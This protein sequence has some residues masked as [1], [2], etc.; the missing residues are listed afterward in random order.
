MRGIVIKNVPSV[1]GE[2]KVKR[3]DSNLVIVTGATQP[4]KSVE[5][6][7]D[8]RRSRY[9]WIIEKYKDGDLH[10]KPIK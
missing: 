4:F 5:F 2:Y 9:D 3:L 10:L 8:S 1:I 6:K 7:L